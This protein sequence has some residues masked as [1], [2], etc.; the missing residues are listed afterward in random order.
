VRSEEAL[1][2][3]SRREFI[4][5]NEIALRSAN[6]SARWL[7]WVVARRLAN[8]AE[9]IRL[10]DEARQLARMLAR[11]VITAKRNEQPGGQ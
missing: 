1:G 2:S 10:L 8:T 4:R 3:S 6:E 5:Y 9:A 11:I 7:R